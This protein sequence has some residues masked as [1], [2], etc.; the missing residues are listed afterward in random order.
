MSETRDFDVCEPAN[1]GRPLWVVY[2]PAACWPSLLCCKLMPYS[3]DHQLLPVGTPSK[4]VCI[5]G[6]SRWKRQY[7]FRTLGINVRQW[8]ERSGDV[9]WF[10]SFEAAVAYLETHIG[11]GP[12]G[13]AMRG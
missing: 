12:A 7:G 4:N 3:K 6:L 2:G 1:H 9:R 10:D 5:W 13:K 8:V 11:P